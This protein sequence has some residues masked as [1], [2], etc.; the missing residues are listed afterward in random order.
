MKARAIAVTLLFALSGCL[1]VIGYGAAN[2]TPEELTHRSDDELCK[3]YYV[4]KSPAL[5]AE[6][7]RRH[8][9]DAANLG[10]IDKEQVA[11][12]FNKC[13]AVAAWNEPNDVHRTVTGSSVSEQWCYGDVY[14]MSCIYFDEAGK[15]TS[16]QN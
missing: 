1:N 10:L 5:K 4:V 7:D 11:V 3:A 14:S 15:V 2:D 16:I 13:E 8:L 9:I 6:I 12:G